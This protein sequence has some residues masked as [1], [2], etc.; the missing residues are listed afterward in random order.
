MILSNKI[1][2]VVPEVVVS[3]FIRDFK[4]LSKTAEEALSIL[5]GEQEL[6]RSQIWYRTS[7]RLHT[8]L[9]TSRIQPR[10]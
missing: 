6:A 2:Q 8:R 10:V 4:P 7:C 9:G 3:K 1:N 5:G